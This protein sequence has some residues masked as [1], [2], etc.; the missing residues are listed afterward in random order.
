[1]DLSRYA[2]TETT[3]VIAPPEVVYDLV[4]D[5]TRMGEWS[6][7]CTGAVWDDDQQLWFTGSNSTPQMTWETRCRV[8]SAERGR[9]FTFVNCGADGSTELVRWTYRFEPQAEGTSLSESWQ[10]LEGFAPYMVAMAPSM[11]A[12]QYLDSIRQATVDG[13]AHTLAQLKAAAEA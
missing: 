7:V 11:D 12:E 5:V 8:D 10:V 2:H 1:M 9:S 4:A 13:M 3:T 6:P